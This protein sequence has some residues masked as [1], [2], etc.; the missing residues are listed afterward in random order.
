MT[1]KHDWNL[2]PE[3]QSAL[4]LLESGENVFLTGGAGSGKSYLVKAFMS[5]LNPKSFPILASTGAAAVILGGR[6]FH[7]F[8]GLG[9][10]E[11][12]AEKTFARASQ[13]KKILKRLSQVEGVVIDEISMIPMS[14]FET[15]EKIVRAARDSDLPWGGLRV[16]VVGDFA[17]LPPISKTA[18]REWS[19]LS[20]IWEKTGFINCV[21]SHNQRV[22]DDEFLNILSEVRQGVVSDAVKSYLNSRLREHDI[23]DKSTRLFPRRDQSELFNQSELAQIPFPEVCID[24]IYLGQEKFVEVLRKACPIPQQIKIKKEARVMFLQ[25]DPQKRWI[26]G[27]STATI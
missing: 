4:E 9:I 19:F 1:K 13:D 14:A 16:I 6:T 15:A 7:S 18:H 23:E 24:S 11:G 22:K 8:F 21:L 17:Q 12:G 3:Q 27:T 20:Q 10:M 2:S 25:N 5:Q 26:N